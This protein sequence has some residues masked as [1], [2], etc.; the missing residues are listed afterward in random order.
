MCRVGPSYFTMTGWWYS[1]SPLKNDGVR[2]LGWWHSQYMESHKI[3]VPNHQPDEVIIN[4][5]FQD[6]SNMFRILV[7]TCWNRLHRDRSELQYHPYQA[8]GITWTDE[9]P[10]SMS[11]STTFFGKFFWH[12]SPKLR[13]FPVSGSRTHSYPSGSVRVRLASGQWKPWFQAHI[14]DT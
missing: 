5:N 14:S 12:L 1:P 7:A 11:T 9:F 4:P 6:N 10:L 2:Q 3:H 13:T 8:P